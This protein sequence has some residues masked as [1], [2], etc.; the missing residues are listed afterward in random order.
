MD[1]TS[2]E[3]GKGGKFTIASLR[4]DLDSARSGKTWLLL[5]EGFRSQSAGC[6]YPLPASTMELQMIS[7]VFLPPGKN[8]CGCLY[9][10]RAI[11]LWKERQNRRSSAMHEIAHKSQKIQ[12]K[13]DK[14]MER[15]KEARTEI[16]DTLK[17]IKAEAAKAVASMTD[18]FSMGR[19]G[20]D[21]QMRA[22]LEGKKWQEERIS[23]SAFRDCF[24]MVTQAVKGLGL[25]SEQRNK[26][27]EAIMKEAADAIEQ[28]RDTVALAPGTGEETEH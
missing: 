2:P 7:S 5:P 14:Y 26:A 12:K 21:G 11:T 3:T 23:A 10:K 6:H 4:L 8:D 13:Q 1:K 22:H 19:E 17:G 28:T 24:R 25:P 20:L 27:Q 18:L 9:I 16:S 15:V